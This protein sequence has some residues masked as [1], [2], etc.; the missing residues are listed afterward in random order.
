MTLAHELVER[1]YAV[2]RKAVDAEMV[3][4]AAAAVNAELPQELSR[5]RVVS[6]TRRTF[7]PELEA[8]RRLLSLY[9][10]SSLRPICE[11][12][13]GS[14]GFEPVRRV[15]IQVRLP[16]AVNVQPDK[17]LHVDGL[18]CAHLPEGTVNT[19]TLLVGVLL[20]AVTEHDGPLEVVPGGHRA[21]AC[22][23]TQHSVDEL[24][25]GAEVPA[26]VAAFRRVAVTGKPGDAVIAHHLT[27]HAAGTNGGRAP[28]VMAYF[29]LRHRRH[30]ELAKSA[31]TDPWLELPGLLRMV[32]HDRPA[33]GHAGAS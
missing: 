33:L 9:E 8:D 29:R 30:S 28:R 13:A 22:W 24:P 32:G 4:A 10:H 17:P 12:L 25:G 19:F 27:P 11:P 15:Q 20:T 14:D 26:E 16:E 31:L 5:E 18:A 1:G 2:I 23:L 3:G 6:Y 7:V 21:M